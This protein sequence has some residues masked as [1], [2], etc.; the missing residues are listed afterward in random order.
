MGMKKKN[1]KKKTARERWA[2]R[3]R[4]LERLPTVQKPYQ[5][6]RAAQVEGNRVSRGK[7]KKT[8]GGGVG[9]KPSGRPSNVATNP[10][11]FPKRAYSNSVCFGHLPVRPPC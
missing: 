6:S 9:L 5:N 11:I 2:G 4:A 3:L 8:G 1:E 7:K 10:S